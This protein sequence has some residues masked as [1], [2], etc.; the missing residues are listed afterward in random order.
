MLR[1][2]GVVGC[3]GRGGVAVGSTV[4]LEPTVLRSPRVDLVCAE[5][6]R[7]GNERAERSEQGANA[8]IPCGLLDAGA[9]PGCILLVELMRADPSP[10]SSATVQSN[11][12]CC[13]GADSCR[14]LVVS[15]P[16][17]HSATF[18]DSPVAL[19]SLAPP[20]AMLFTQPPPHHSAGSAPPRFTRADIARLAAQDAEY[21]LRCQWQHSDEG[22]VQN[23]PTSSRFR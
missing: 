1:T 23:R 20:A 19:T 16:R 13:T 22:R 3:G 5:G 7:Q 4:A 14:M 2:I 21:G 18:H 17:S 8:P 9:V 6:G 10:R 11:A 12:D 15:R